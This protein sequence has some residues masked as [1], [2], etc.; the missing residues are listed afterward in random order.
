MLRS[1][2]FRWVAVAAV[3]AEPGILVTIDDAGSSL[4]KASALAAQIM[5]VQP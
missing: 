2:L 5:G 4:E 1:R 3:I